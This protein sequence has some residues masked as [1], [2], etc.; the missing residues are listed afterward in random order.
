M[1]YSK[2]NNKCTRK[3]LMHKSE[4]ILG[5]DTFFL[6]IQNTKTRSYPQLNA[7]MPLLSFFPLPIN[8]NFKF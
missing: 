8:A 4:L 6:L 5:L 3:A 2:T 1:P 7:E